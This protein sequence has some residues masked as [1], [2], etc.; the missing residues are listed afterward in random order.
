MN[1]V[2]VLLLLVLAGLFFF[3]ATRAWRNRRGWI[4]WPGVVLSALLGLVLVLIAG[5]ALKGYAQLNFAPYQYTVS[6]VQVAGTPEQIARGERLAYGCS[7]CHATTMS[8]LPLDGSAGNLLAGGP[9]VGT[10]YAPNLTPGGDMKN[11]SDGLIIRAIREGVDDQGRP[12]LVMASEPFSHLSDDDVQALVAYLRSQPAVEND[13][14]ERNINL[15]GA[16][17]IGAGMFPTS[18]QPPVTE[19][20]VAPPAGTAE[21]GKYL[22]YAT[23]CRDCH[24]P[25]LD[26]SENP[27]VPPGPSLVNSIPAWSEEQFIALFRTGV[28]NTGR[29]VDPTVMPWKTYSHLFTDPELKDIYTFLKTL[30]SAAA[31]K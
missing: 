15:L 7:D 13:T 25:E 10:L 21:Y 5:V 8:Q 1:V 19:K 18:A 9:P 14:P 11:W 30:P 4:K 24:G 28:N 27:F 23:G 17:F 20:I 2:S 22:V 12:L 26:G 31:M 29:A 16:L 3:L 6:D